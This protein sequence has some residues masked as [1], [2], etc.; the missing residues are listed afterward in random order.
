MI[1]DVALFNNW[2]FFF[3]FKC[4]IL[5]PSLLFVEHKVV[6]EKRNRRFGLHLEIQL[7]QRKNFPFLFTRCSLSHCVSL[8]IF[9]YSIYFSILFCLLSV[10][11]FF[12][13]A[14]SLVS[15]TR[16]II[17][18]SDESRHLSTIPLK[19]SHLFKIAE[20]VISF[21]F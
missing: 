21:C 17:K 13:T 1:R 15:L 10:M 8:T 20:S 9:S 6:P 5:F 2:S 12:K 11:P 7:E 16:E 3:F 14:P 19:N 18:P 4:M